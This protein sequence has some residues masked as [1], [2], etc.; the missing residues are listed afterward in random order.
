MF[1]HVCG[2]SLPLSRQKRPNS[3]RGGGL[4][5]GGLGGITSEGSETSETGEEV[6]KWVVTRQP[7]AHVACKGKSRVSRER[8]PVP[9]LR[10]GRV[11]SVRGRANVCCGRRRVRPDGARACR[12]PR[13]SS[14]CASRKR[15]RRRHRWR[16]LVGSRG[17]VG[18]PPLACF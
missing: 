8:G 2:N 14:A 18:R 6:G 15:T 11:R 17:S 5:T 4:Q 12:R 16:A 10:V 3:I 7:S 9:L 13:P 1:A